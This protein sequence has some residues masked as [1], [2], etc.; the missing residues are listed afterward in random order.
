MEMKEIIQ[1]VEV[2]CTQC[3]ERYVYA[4]S[5]S[6]KTDRPQ[7]KL[8]ALL[9]S[10]GETLNET[11]YARTHSVVY[12]SATLTVDG[13]FNSFSQAMGLNES[14]FSVADELLL[15]S[16]YDF[17][18]QMVVYVVNDMPEPNDPS[19][20]GAL[21]RLLID[22][23]RVQNGS[24]LTLFTN[25][26]EMEKCF[27][28]VQPALKGD[29]LRVVCQKWGVSVKGLRDDF[30]ADEHLVPFRSEELLGR[31]RRAGR[32]A[33]GRRDTEIAL[34]EADGSPFLRTG[35]LVTMPPGRRYVLPAAVLETKQAAGRLIRKAD[36]RGILILADKRLIT[37]GYGKTFL[38]SLPSQNIRFLSAAQI[39][40]EIAARR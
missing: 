14:E 40:D 8:E 34:L 25:R 3:P 11:L 32:H 37:K 39:V 23:H 29:D 30:L 13:S 12:A 9:V 2:I 31:V 5:L 16:S 18:N 28:E 15:A 10:V 19:Y 36:D 22:A 7:N 38:R 27:E 1:N 4:A 17:D 20:L 24:M 26:R 21:Q 33:E 6:R 35:P